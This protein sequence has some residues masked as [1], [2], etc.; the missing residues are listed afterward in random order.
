MPP[1]LCFSAALRSGPAAALRVG[2]L[3]SSIGAALTVGCG[4]PAAEAPIGADSAEDSV[5]QGNAAQGIAAADGARSRE[6]T[7][8]PTG[9]LAL[10]DAVPWSASTVVR[11]EISAEDDVGVTEL[12]I[13]TLRRCSRWQ[14]FT[15]K[16]RFDLGPG[17]GERTLRLWLRDAAGNQSAPITTLVGIDRRGPADGAVAATPQPGGF[18]LA[19]SGF[20]DDQSGVV[21]YIV[22]A[23]TEGGTP[24][25]ST[26]SAV[27]W[28][29]VGPSAAVR[30]LGSGEH[31]VRVCAVD[32]VGN[33]SRGVELRASPSPDRSPPTVTGIRLEGGARATTSRAVR[34]EPIGAD[35]ADI[36]RVCFSDSPGPC[37]RD[38]RWSPGLTVD[39]SEGDGE[40]W[41]YA[42]FFDAER[43]AAAPV[44][45][46]ITLDRTAP[47]DGTF[48]LSATPTALNLSWGGATDATTGLAGYRLVHSLGLTPSDCDTGDLLYAGTGSTFSFGPVAPGERHAFRLCA[49]DGVGNQSRGISAVQDTLAEYDAPVVDLLT[50]E[51][52]AA[53]TI[54]R[55]ISVQ[56]RARDASGVAR[57]CLS[58]TSTCGVWQ[59]YAESSTFTLPASYGDHTLSVWLEDSLGNRTSAPATARIIYGPDNDGDGYAAPMDCDDAAAG[60]FPGAVELCNGQDDDCDGT[61]DVGAA[62]AP[63]WHP[64]S[65]RDGFGSSSVSLRA[66]AAPAGHIADGSDCEDSDAAAHP[67]ALD[68]CDGADDDCDGFDNP[69]DTCGALVWV[70]DRWDGVLRGVDGWTGEVREQHTGLGTMIGV[71]LDADGNRY[72]GAYDRGE[73]IQ[74]TPDDTRTVLLTGLGGVHDVKWSPTENS[75]LIAVPGG[76]RVIEYLLD[77]GRALTLASGLTEPISAMRFPDDPRVFVSERSVNRLSVIDNGVVSPFATV[78]RPAVLAPLGNGALIVTVTGGVAEIDRV[79]GATRTFSTTPM[80]AICPHPEPGRLAGTQHNPYLLG[81]ELDGSARVIGATLGTGW[82]CS[83][84]SAWDSDGDGVLAMTWGGDDCDDEDALVQPDH[85]SCPVA[86]SCAEA[87]DMGRDR[88]NGSYL[89]DPDGIDRGMAPFTVTCDMSTEGGGWTAI[90]YAAD[91]PFQQQH[92]GGDVVR[93][94]PANFSLGLSDAQINAVRAIS[95]EGKQRYVGLCSGVIHYYYTV[96][97]S[98]AYAFGFAFH[99]GSSFVAGDRA[100]GGVGTVTADGCI[101]NGREGGAL[102]RATTFDLRSRDVPVINVSSRDNGDGGEHFGSPLRDNPAYL[103]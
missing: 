1:S 81:L 84:D 32:A 21:S 92:T 97:A 7:S 38:L 99:G 70:A 18:D 22:A 3:A 54:R 42:T 82:G 33:Q 95:T 51:G 50:V 14:P 103:R 44:G 73:L 86:R 66:C 56:L 93:W 47:T 60:R 8:P 72:V 88:G 91:L 30:G 5:A 29:G 55:E 57:M 24:Y 75:L 48:A 68:I 27:V 13:S 83:S 10:V 2:A 31:A 63:T 74:I 37:T 34:V 4:P 28:R 45:A 102:G 62:D 61:T 65:D 59:A 36:A 71:A 25:C 16:L 12:C 19:F 77:E 6:D 64:D 43:N 101:G 15:D 94:L 76:G 52:G 100:L 69:S 87:L 46:R 80:T 11:L 78:P 9:T 26:D 89:I 67:G 17:N 53:A 96:G 41:V 35:P 23:R 98:W 40:K 39:L 85:G 58:A 79:T 90:P 49:V 20:T